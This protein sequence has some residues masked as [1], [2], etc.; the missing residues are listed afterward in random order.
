[1][2][3]VLDQLKQIENSYKNTFMEY[4]TVKNHPVKEPISVTSSKFGGRPYFDDISKYPVDKNNKPMLHLAQINF[5][6][7][8]SLLGFPKSGILQFFVADDESFGL[9]IEDMTK[10]EGFKVIYLRENE[11][12]QEKAVPVED[13]RVQI[14]PDYFFYYNHKLSFELN[15][16]AISLTDFRCKIRYKELSTE[17]SDYYWDKIARTQEHKIGGYSHFGQD[18]PRYRSYKE[19]TIQLLQILSTSCNDLKESIIIGKQ[20]RGTIHFLIKPQ[21]LENLDFSKVLYHWDTY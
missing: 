2:N 9:N 17:V 14:P 6:E 4:I 11:I 1:M 7:V 8:P 16:A 12:H 3:K 15:K 5:S 13:F 21:D 20:L 10:Q 18:D 19:Y